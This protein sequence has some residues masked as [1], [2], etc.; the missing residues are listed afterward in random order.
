VRLG[1]TSCPFTAGYWT[2][3]DRHANLLAGNFRMSK[4]LAGRKRLADLDQVVAQ[5][6]HRT[7]F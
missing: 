5:E 7:R 2:F 4:P 1:E 3:L 6:R